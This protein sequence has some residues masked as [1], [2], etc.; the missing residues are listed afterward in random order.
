MKTLAMNDTLSLHEICG[1]DFMI[2][3]IL[4]VCT[5]KHPVENHSIG[6]GFHNVRQ[7][8]Y[9]NLDASDTI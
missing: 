9:D 3:S 2:S 8:I 1:S 4:H 7:Y 5:I 6:H